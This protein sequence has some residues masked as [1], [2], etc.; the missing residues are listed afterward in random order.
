MPEL[1]LARPGISHPLEAHWSR[2]P[3][4][5]LGYLAAAA[6]E[7]GIDVGV[8]DAKLEGHRKVSQTVGAI[9][10][11][12]PR[13]LGLSAMTMG[14][15][16]AREIAGLLKRSRP[17][18]TII[19]GGVHANALPKESLTESDAFDYVIAGEGEWSLSELVIALQEGKGIDSIPGLYIRDGQGGVVQSAPP[20][21]EDV[22]KLPFPAWELFPRTRVYA[23]MTERGC[24]Y[25]C[26]FCSHNMGRKLRTRP[27]ENVKEEICWLY[28]DFSPR[29]I[30]F[31][32]ETFGLDPE[33][34]E[35]LL[36]WLMDFNRDNGI[37]FKAQTRVD[38]VSGRMLRLMK[39]AGFEYLELGV[40]AGDSGVLARS[41]KGITLTQAEEAVKLVRKAGLRPWV[42]FIIGL[43]GE[44]EQTVRN[45]IEFAV[46]LNPDWISVALIV[47][48]PGSEI[49]QW[50]QRGKNGYRLVSREWARFDKYIGS[51]SVE[52]ES[53]D[54]RRM[55]RLQIRMYLETYLRN[56]RFR[57]LLRLFWES[58]RL[59]L[60]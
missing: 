3:P 6:R 50:A 51:A 10:A 14:Y 31:E 11:L 19:L 16:R 29:E 22:S 58:R 37:V 59:A 27:L 41:G 35:E 56:L 53:L 52:L 9:L 60:G 20:V 46:N 45:M 40:E 7:R 57:E 38:R 55:R 44:N 17:D 18:L 13:F 21:F 34:S 39:L 30:Y 4:L 12:E 28:K 47:A 1:V 36:E 24:P 42:N 15:P 25:Q 26:V 2:V 5:G 43:P 48:Y 32:D 23:M 49:Y 54:H 8:V 33:R